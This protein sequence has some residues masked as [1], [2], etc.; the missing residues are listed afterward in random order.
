M[1]DNNQVARNLVLP[2][3]VYCKTYK[4]LRTW[5]NSH[6]FSLKRGLWTQLCLQENSIV[7]QLLGV[8]VCITCHLFDISVVTLFNQHKKTWTVSARTPASYLY[9]FLSVPHHAWLWSTHHHMCRCWSTYT[10]KC[11]NVLTMKLRGVYQCSPQF[12]D[13]KLETVKAQLFALMMQPLVYVTIATFLTSAAKFELCWLACTA[14]CP[15]GLLCAPHQHTW[16]CSTHHCRRWS[17]NWVPKVMA[18]KL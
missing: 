11:F 10:E 1:V 8:Y 6:N 12:G 2:F 9:T 4:N 15:C 17:T 7:H 3:Q 18:M 14:S 13:S 5:Q 16:L